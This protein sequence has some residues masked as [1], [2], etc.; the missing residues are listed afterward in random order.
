METKYLK[1]SK[2]EEKHLVIIVSQCNGLELSLEQSKTMYT[3]NPGM[4]KTLAINKKILETL[5]A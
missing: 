1:Q 5:S 2:N 4:K 3:N